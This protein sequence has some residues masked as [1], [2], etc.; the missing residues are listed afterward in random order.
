VDLDDA[1]DEVYSVAPAEFVAVRNRLSAEALAAGDDALARQIK[2]LKKPAAPAALLNLLARRRSASVSDYAEL[3]GKLRDAQSG[4]AGSDL[5]DLM[6]KR[7]ALAS[8]LL[9]SAAELAPEI[10]VGAGPTVQRELQGVLLLAVADP[11]VAAK[12]IA[13]RLAAL[14]TAGEPD[15][16]PSPASATSATPANSTAPA[17]AARPTAAETKRRRESERRVQKAEAELAK[18]Q[19]QVRRARDD[20]EHLGRRITQLQHEIEGLESA[21]HKAEHLVAAAETALEHA[22]QTL[23]E[24]TAVANLEP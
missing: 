3:G 16:A 14:P 10:G 12:L 1:M 8:E 19:A 6:R 5:R 13:G 20:A 24:A 9:A 7:Q 22:R 2:A 17:P 23:D 21:R 15:G 11:D 18:R 4:G